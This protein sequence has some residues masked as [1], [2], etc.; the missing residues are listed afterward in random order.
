MHIGFGIILGLMNVTYRNVLGFASLSFISGYPFW[1]GLSFIITGALCISA[2][3]Q[4]SPSLIKSSLGMNIVSSVF[5]FIGV[6]LLLVDVS[7][8]GQPNQDY[9]A[10]LAGKGISAML[11]IFSILEFCLTCTTA[12]YA[13]Q[14]IINTNGMLAK[15]ILNLADAN[16]R[17]SPDRPIPEMEEKTLPE[18]PSSSWRGSEHTVGQTLVSL[19]TRSAPSTL[20][21]IGVAQA[22]QEPAVAVGDLRDLRSL[23]AGWVLGALV[24]Q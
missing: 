12:Y 6:I 24:P 20:L 18:T 19:R 9:W 23:R 10:V 15:H 17:S 8:N 21:G 3:K 22:H 13:S 2:C 4:L 16:I 14:A 11:I 1:G 7:I 5:V